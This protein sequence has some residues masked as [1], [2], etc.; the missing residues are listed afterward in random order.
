VDIC[1]E[2]WEWRDGRCQNEGRTCPWGTFLSGKACVSYCPAG[3][4]LVGFVCVPLPFGGPGPCPLPLVRSPLSGACVIPVDVIV[5]ERPA[6]CPEGWAW[7]EQAE[8]CVRLRPQTAEKDSVA[9]IQ[10]CLAALGY[11]PGDIDGIEGGKTR[12]AWA[13]FRRD[14]GLGETEVALNDAE[15][16]GALYVRCAVA[17]DQPSTA[18]DAATTASGDGEGPF[19]YAEMACAEGRVRE[20]LSA[21]LGREVPACSE[22]CIPVPENLAPGKAA[23]AAAGKEG[24]NWCRN[25]LKLGEAGLVCPGQK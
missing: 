24:I 6:A 10:R 18:Q 23:A 22:T 15:T 5:A 9:W 7:S 3:S 8:G 25:C 14:V 16:L 17:Q 19:S 13:A 12:S 2:G 20:W 11:D 21:T 4:V 1:P